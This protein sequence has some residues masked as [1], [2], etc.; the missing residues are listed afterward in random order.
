VAPDAL[1]RRALDSLAHTI[2]NARSDSTIV[3][4]ILGY[5]RRARELLTRS[6]ARY[7]DAR[8]SDVNRIARALRPNVII[9]A[10]EPYGAGAQALGTRSPDFW[11]EYVRRTADVAHYVNPNIRIGIAASSYGTRDSTL[12]AWAASRNSPVDI[13]GFSL[14]P[15]YDGA[16]SLDTHMRIARRW[17]RLYDRPKMHWVWTAGGYPIAHGERSQQL[18]LRGVFSWATSQPAVNGVVVFEAGDYDTQ[19]GMRAPNGHLRPALGELMRAI[20]SVRESAR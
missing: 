12:Y 15:G 18:A 19:Q 14:M 1:Q 7:L 11:I 17:M 20:A 13:V 2:D 10:H 6:P 4:V 16:G 9:P 3:I 8:V 5:P